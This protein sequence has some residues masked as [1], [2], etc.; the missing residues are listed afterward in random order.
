MESRNKLLYPLLLAVAIAVILFTVLGIV[1]TMGNL[2]SVNAAEKPPLSKNAASSA[3]RL[4]Q[5]KAGAPEEIERAA[6]CSNCGIVESIRIINRSGPGAG[7]GFVVGGL[8]GRLASNRLGSD[9]RRAFMTGLGDAD[10]SYA[11]IAVE[12]H[13]TKSTCFEILI[14][15]DNGRV[16][17]TYGA[18]DAP[19]VVGDRVRVV[20]GIVVPQI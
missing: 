2:P 5:N 6:V 7:P 17:A 15:L 10:G 8:T 3:P 11:G 16:N 20:N 18:S 12:A 13:A 19:F 14:R 9:N 4:R 1:A